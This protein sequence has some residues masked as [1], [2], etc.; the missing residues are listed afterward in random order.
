[1]YSVRTS[2]NAAKRRREARAV[3]IKVS[4]ASA[5]LSDYLPL[6]LIY[7]EE[8]SYGQIGSYL[9]RRRPLNPVASIESAPASDGN[10]LF[11]IV[12]HLKLTHTPLLGALLLIL[13]K[14]TGLSEDEF[15]AWKPFEGV[16]SDMRSLTGRKSFSAR[17]LK[18][19]I[20]R[21]REALATG[22]LPRGLIQTHRNKKSYRFAIRR[23][24]AAVIGGDRL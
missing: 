15:V 20:Y 18:Q 12:I 24:K 9:R 23:E 8:G 10:I 4:H 17:A 14:D 7:L 3:F 19:A 13:A 21:L 11:T 2:R 16:L 22:G 1:M 6:F 5:T